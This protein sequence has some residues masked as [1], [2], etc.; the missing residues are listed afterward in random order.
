[1]PNELKFNIKYRVPV[2]IIFN[3]LT[4]QNEITKFTQCLAKFDK[5]IGGSFNFYDGFI[6]GENQEIVENKKIV[7]KWKFNNWKDYGQITFTFKEI[8]GNECLIGVHLK[9]IPERDIFNNI[10]D[11]KIL[12]NGFRSQIFQK[13]NDWLGYPL[14]NDADQSS[15]E[16]DN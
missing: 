16:E 5:N 8:Q 2:K 4:D 11:L 10:I 1:M 3:T 15:D 7:Q 12:E 9:N 13:I 14:N 6:T